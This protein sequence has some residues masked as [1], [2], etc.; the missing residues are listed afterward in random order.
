MSAPAT[1]TKPMFAR[2]WG[3]DDAVVFENKHEKDEVKIHVE[4]KPKSSG[5]KTGGYLADLKQR[6]KEGCVV[7]GDGD[8]ECCQGIQRLGEGGCAFK[9]K[10]F[11]G[12]CPKHEWMYV[13]FGWSVATGSKKSDPRMMRILGKEGFMRVPKEHGR[14]FMDEHD[15]DA[16]RSERDDV[17]RQNNLLL[18]EIEALRAALIKAGGKHEDV[19]R[20]VAEKSTPVR[21]TQ[22]QPSQKKVESPDPVGMDVL[23]KMI[24]AGVAAG[25][26][27]GLEGHREELRELRSVVEE[28]EKRAEE[29]NKVVTE[30]LKEVVTSQVKLVEEVNAANQKVDFVF[31]MASARARRAEL[32][33]LE[34]R[35]R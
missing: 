18:A 27:A 25:V 21:E 22:P 23:E 29:Q 14:G 15:V 12:L 2:N 19:K 30:V 8:F 7:A 6:A 16:L 32:E 13:T 33:D 3:D 9:A 5:Q 26:A 20:V 28:R 24:A 31:S 1:A 10:E 17:C 4:E 11:G 34:F 35:L